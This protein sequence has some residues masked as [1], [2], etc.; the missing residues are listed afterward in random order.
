MIVISIHDV[1]L[2]SL[3]RWTRRVYLLLNGQYGYA[4]GIGYSLFYYHIRY[5]INSF[6]S[7]SSTSSPNIGTET[8][9]RF[10]LT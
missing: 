1:F 5:C 3:K 2:W 4:I 6:E 9:E 7:D 10:N 8:L